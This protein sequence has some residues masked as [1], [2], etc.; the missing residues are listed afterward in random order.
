MKKECVDNCVVVV[1]VVV[2][3]HKRIPILIQGAGTPLGSTGG[4]GTGFVFG[5]DLSS[6]FPFPF[7]FVFF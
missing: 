1:V 5:V 2:E 4:T 6:F 3:E 7:F